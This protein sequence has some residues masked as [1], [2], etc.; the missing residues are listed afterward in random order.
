MMLLPSSHVAGLVPLPGILDL[1]LFEPYRTKLV[2]E[3]T[4]TKMILHEYKTKNYITFM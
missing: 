2:E 4:K 1:G 3:N